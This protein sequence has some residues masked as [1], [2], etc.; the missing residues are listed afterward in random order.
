VDLDGRVRAVE[1]PRE[2]EAAVVDTG[3]ALVRRVPLRRVPA[4]E[5]VPVRQLDLGVLGQPDAHRPGVGQRAAYLVERRAQ[6]YPLAQH[7]H[8][9]RPFG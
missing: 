4:P 2:G 9:A 6:A 5:R 7:A 8:P 3:Q 1:P